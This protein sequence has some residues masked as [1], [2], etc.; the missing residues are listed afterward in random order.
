[1]PRNLVFVEK[2]INKFMTSW[3]WLEGRGLWAAHLNMSLWGVMGWGLSQVWGAE[4]GFYYLKNA[5]RQ[6]V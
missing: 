5:Y 4:S 6:H 3:G 2:D 1:M